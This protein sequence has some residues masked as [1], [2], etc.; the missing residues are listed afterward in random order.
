MSGQ[1]YRPRNS[2]DFRNIVEETPFT[3][4]AATGNDVPTP[5][6][7]HLPAASSAQTPYALQHGEPKTVNYP[8]IA[9]AGMLQGPGVQMIPPPYPG[10]ASNAV[11]VA[12]PNTQMQMGTAIPTTVVQGAWVPGAVVPQQP[13]ALQHGQPAVAGSKS[14]FNNNPNY[15]L[16]YRASNNICNTMKGILE[17]AA[18]VLV[19][20]RDGNLRLVHA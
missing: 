12:Q 4:M 17:I 16:Q 8:Q 10:Y 18:R 3:P 20:V 2:P 11:W 1:E 9:Q 14:I 15:T 19:M 13:T 6:Q 7:Q 5:L